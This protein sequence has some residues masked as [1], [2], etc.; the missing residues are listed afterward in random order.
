[1]TREDA[2]NKAIGILTYHQVNFC[3]SKEA[4]ANM[5]EIINA[6]EKIDQECEGDVPDINIGKIGKDATATDCVKRQDVEDAIYDYS[7]SC[8]V[9]YAQIMEFIDKLPSVQPKI[10]H[11]VKVIEENGH[12]FYLCSVCKEGTD[13]NYDW[14]PFCGCKMQEVKNE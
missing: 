2:L 10:G 13:E 3:K 1:M 5:N 8:D 14:C 11:W 6:L 4:V 12:A 7:R 9:N